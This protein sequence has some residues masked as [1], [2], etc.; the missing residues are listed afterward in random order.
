MQIGVLLLA[1]VGGCRRG[2]ARHASELGADDDDPDD[3]DSVRVHGRA[4]TGRDK[5]VAM[6]P[7]QGSV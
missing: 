6:T 1:A 4:V 3:D 2:D 5:L 7:Q